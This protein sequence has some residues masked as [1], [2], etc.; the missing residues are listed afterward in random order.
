MSVTKAHGG[1]S[2]RS[3]GDR[4]VTAVHDGA[5]WRVEFL[6]A[7]HEPTA[8]R[9]ETHAGLLAAGDHYLGGGYIGDALDAGLMQDHM[10]RVAARR[11]HCTHPAQ[12]WCDC[13]W[14][15]L[16]RAERVS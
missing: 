9:L 7:G 13:D 15:R 16:L 12:V 14:C 8:A 2:M 6:R 4:V 10:A 5:A 3:R 1:R 11:L